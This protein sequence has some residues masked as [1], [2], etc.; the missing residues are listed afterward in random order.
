MPA[1]CILPTCGNTPDKERCIALH[2]VPFYDDERPE[3]KKR[4]KRWVD[5]IKSKRADRWELSKETAICSVHFSRDSFIRRVLVPGTTPRLITDGLGVVPYPTI[6]QVKES[7]D[8]SAR[9]GRARSK[10]GQLQSDSYTTPCLA[11]PSF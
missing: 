3:A 7:G 10:V 6:L 2:R 8:K 11:L 4:R 5:F 9:A 1:R